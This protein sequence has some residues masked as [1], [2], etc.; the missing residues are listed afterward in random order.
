MIPINKPFLPD[1]KEYQK[2]LSDIWY[3]NWLTNDGPVVKKLEERLTE[4]LGVANLSFVSNGTIA[5][6]IALKALGLEGEIITT[7]FSFIATTS[8]VIWENC[9][10]VFADIDKETFNIDPEQIERS[11]SPNTTAILAT[12]V[13]GNPCEIDAIK[14]IADKHNLA[15]I[16]DGAHCFGSLYDGESVLNYGDISTIS[17]HATKLFHSVE[18]GGIICNKDVANK[19]SLLRNFGHNGP[20]KFDGV[21]IN[22]KNSEF[23]AAMG[24]ANLPYID[25]I[26]EKRRK[27]HQLYDEYLQSLPILKQKINGKGTSN[28]SYYPIVLNDE[29]TCLKVKENLENKSIFPRRYFYPSL[30]TLEY[31]DTKKKMNNSENVANSILCLPL[32]YDLQEAEIANVSQVIRD[33]LTIYNI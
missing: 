20:E 32:Y 12:H 21:G 3:R 1:K 31:V 22:G 25:T 13:F 33:T 15:V 16:Y 10:P 4:K 28:Y 23:H 5:L 24:L 9:K 7:P 6:Q 30:N 19:I 2:Y 11:I 17:F 8:T 29:A 18:G 26:L 14:K 27:D